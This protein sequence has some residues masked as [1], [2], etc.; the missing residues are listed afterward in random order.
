M[1]GAGGGAGGGGGG[2][3]GGKAD[4]R[5]ITSKAFQAEAIAAIVDFCTASNYRG[6]PM[7][8]KV[9]GAPTGKD[10]A[11]VVAHLCQRIDASFAVAGRVEDEAHAVLKA[12]RCVASSLLT[13]PC[14]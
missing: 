1:G 6:G 7:N 8:A 3:A 13:L 4:P 14:C 2:G 12:L 9:L 10:F 11:A 5:P